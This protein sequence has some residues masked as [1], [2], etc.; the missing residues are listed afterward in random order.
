[1]LNSEQLSLLLRFYG[2]DSMESCE[3]DI[4]ETEEIRT[5]W[6]LRQEPDGFYRIT[7]PGFVI[8]SPA[9]T[10]ANGVK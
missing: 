5:R 8:T 9:I 7:K 4:D 10:A 3:S 6:F 2:D 1:V